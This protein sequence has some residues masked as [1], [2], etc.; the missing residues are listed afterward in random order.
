MGPRTKQTL[1]ALT[2]AVLPRSEEFYLPIEDEIVAGIDRLISSLPP[3]FRIGFSAGVT[4][5]EWCPLVVVGKPMRFSSLTEAER[6]RVVEKWL[7]ARAT[8]VRE[9]MKL[10]SG[11]VALLFYDD[12]RVMDHIGYFI[13]DH[14]QQVNAS[15]AVP[16]RSTVPLGGRASAR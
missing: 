1:R 12:P 16:A 11:L 3:L 2:V 7:R 5:L 14:I 9:L 10:M 6:R 4:A 8:P 13:E 15:P